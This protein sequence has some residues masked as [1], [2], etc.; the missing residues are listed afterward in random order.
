MTLGSPL[1]SEGMR[2]RNGS[3]GKGRCGWGKTGRKG[4]RGTGW[5]VIYEKRI[6][7]K[8]LKAPSLSY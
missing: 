2:R 3:G 7:K 6:Q 1:F 5:D 8:K 4:W